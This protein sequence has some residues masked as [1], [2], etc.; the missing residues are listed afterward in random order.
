MHPIGVFF[1]LSGCVAMCSYVV[2]KND[3]GEEQYLVDKELSFKNCGWDSNGKV[4]LMLLRNACPNGHV[5]HIANPRVTAAGGMV[6]FTRKL[7]SHPV[8]S[9]KRYTTIVMSASQLWVRYAGTPEEDTIKYALSKGKHASIED[10]ATYI[11]EEVSK[12]HTCQHLRA[13]SWQHS[14]MHL[15]GHAAQGQH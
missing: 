13:S 12:G 4:E 14:V 5:L 7:H 9:A 11:R 8:L 6:E 3:A 15:A 1:P 10:T 2:L